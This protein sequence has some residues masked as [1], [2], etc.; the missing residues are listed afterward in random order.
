MTIKNHHI[1]IIRFIRSAV[2]LFAGAALLATG[3]TDYKADIQNLNKRLD[4]LTA[5]K[6]A[7]LE[8]QVQGLLSTVATLE[9]ATKHDE[10]LQKVNKSIIDL[11]TALKA[12]YEKKIK[13]A[14]NIALDGKLDK[15]TLD[16]A[17]REIESGMQGLSDRIK[18]IEDADFQKQINDLNDALGTRLSK[19]EALLAGDWDGKTVKQAIDAV[20]QSV[21]DLGTAINGELGL[22][23]ARL[24]AAEAAVKKIN[25]ETIPAINKVISDLRDGK[26]DTSDYDAYK[27]ATAETIGLM[28]EAI[29]ALTALTAG[30][31]EGKTIKDN[32]DGIL[33][34]LDDYVL[35][36][37]FE[38]FVKIAATKEELNGIESRLDGRLDVLEALLAGDWGGL[39][40]KKYIE[41]QIS[42]LQSQLDHITN[43]DGT[44]RLDV[45]ENAASELDKLVGE[46][47]LTHIKFAE[48][49][50]GESG[51]GLRGYIDDGDAGTLKAAKD[52]T[53]SQILLVKNLIDQITNADGTGRLDVLENV[54]SK[55]VGR[56]QSIVFVPAF[57]DGKMTM[58]GDGA[59]IN[60]FKIMPADAAKDVVAL[61]STDPD[62]FSFDV[63]TVLTRAG[64]DEVALQ[65][66]VTDIQ[67]NTA[68]ADKGWVDISVGSNFNGLSV[69][70]KAKT[71]S[72]AL[73]I[74]AISSPFYTICLGSGNAIGGHEY[75]D[76][77][78]GLKWAT[79]NVGANSPEE[80]GDYFA[81]GE[82]AAKDNYT[83]A[84]Y[85]HMESGQPDWKYIN[86]YTFADN[87]KE[88]IWYD[89]DTFKGDKGDGVEHRDLA[90]YDY[91]DDAAR[92]IWGSTW[93]IPTDAEWTWLRE[94]CDWTWT[95]D[96]NGT[97]KAGMVVTSKVS[98]F[99]GNSIFL[100]AAGFRYGT[101][102]KYVGSNGDYWFS[103]LHEHYSDFAE[104]VYFHSGVVNWSIGNRF[105]G[106]SVRPVSE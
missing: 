38:A 69:A 20:Q 51:N 83:W 73:V 29:N 26:V 70:D 61:F 6:V 53:D 94:N 92:E 80:Y 88:A 22:L 27:D 35:T 43:A 15:S 48:N 60:T 79:T 76:M 64:G 102:L 84:T 21:V 67:L 31:P 3:C 23:K 19:L 68:N 78:N 13:D 93:R 44:G 12:D 57:D 50:E 96:Y 95:A 104:I 7:T 97:G 42:A 82:V 33:V 8:S 98:G 72:A 5:G 1:M 9:T 25:E 52:Y 89:W 71:Y 90:S 46:T 14:L 77:G 55:L 87:Q 40:V 37:T 56:I 18:T 65:L 30:F 54:V 63:K 45:L 62:A 36:T 66:S 106:M 91:E 49:Y 28:Q 85:A 105:Y 41:N 75:V 17:K 47:I 103:S 16:T 32:I 59:D 81:W 11:E 34:K 4:E 24:D 2:A 58:T 10:D 39:T 99:E 74:D 100:P 101:D 86:K